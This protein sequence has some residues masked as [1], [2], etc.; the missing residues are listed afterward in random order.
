VELGI[1]G[2]LNNCRNHIE[3]FV[4]ENRNFFIFSDTPRLFKNVK[5]R[6]HNNRELIVNVQFKCLN[7]SAIGTVFKNIKYS[8][9][10]IGN[11]LLII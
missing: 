1:S 9:F 4:D 7:Y 2:K 5:N 6:L 8:I 10:I 11:L 3:N